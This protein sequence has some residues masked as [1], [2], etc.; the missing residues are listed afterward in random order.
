M[1]KTLRRKQEEGKIQLG[2]DGEGRKGLEMRKA[3]L[4]SSKAGR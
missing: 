4:T 1:E 2:A 3:G